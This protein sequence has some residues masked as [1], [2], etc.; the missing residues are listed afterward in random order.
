VAPLGAVGKLL[1]SYSRSRLSTGIN[2]TSNKF[3]IG[4]IHSLSKRTQVYG[5]AATV[6]NSNGATS[7]VFP[8]AAGI[9]APN[10]GS[11]GIDLGIRHIF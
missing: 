6:R 2:P 8:G 10:N 4:Y 5:S 9:P 7:N 1:A 3:A 11:R